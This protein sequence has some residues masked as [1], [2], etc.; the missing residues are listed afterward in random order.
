[1]GGK[2][3]DYSYDAVIL[4]D[5]LFVTGAS[6]SYEPGPVNL[7]LLKYNQEGELAWNKTYPPRSYVL[8][9]GTASTRSLRNEELLLDEIR[10]RNPC[11]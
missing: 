3:R 9:Q 5:A 1:M 2:Y 11:D 4:N 6:F 10:A 7:I 8:W